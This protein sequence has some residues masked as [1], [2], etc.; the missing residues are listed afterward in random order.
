VQ[1]ALLH[2]FSPLKSWLTWSCAPVVMPSQQGCQMVCFRT[3]NPNLGKF[4]RA[5]EWKSWY[6]LWPFGKYHSHF[7]YF[8][9]HLVI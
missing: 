1:H 4:W 5:L 9:G 2:L 7:V 8:Y 3:K 6:V